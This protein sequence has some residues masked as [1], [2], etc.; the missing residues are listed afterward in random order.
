MTRVLSTDEDISERKI[1]VTKIL[2]IVE[3]LLKSGW[4]R[5]LTTIETTEKFERLK[6]SRESITYPFFQT[7]RNG[8]EK[9]SRIL[10]MYTK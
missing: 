4:T 5:D 3:V 6:P 2:F 9:N 10:N 8:S 1:F 7:H